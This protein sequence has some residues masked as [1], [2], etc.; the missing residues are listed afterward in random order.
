MYT[1]MYALYRKEGMDH[2]AFVDYWLNT[3]RPIALRM[4]RMRSYEI[5][6]VTESDGVLDQEIDGFVLF[7]FDSKED[8]EFMHDSPEFADTAADAAN[9]ARHFTRYAVDPHVAL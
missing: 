9:F 1:V 5:W 2:E 3:H 7:R 8:F 6:P 4:P